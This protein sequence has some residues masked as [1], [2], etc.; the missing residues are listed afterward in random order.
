MNEEAHIEDNI[1]S[2]NTA[3][4]LTDEELA[5]VQQVEQTYRRLMKAG[6]T[7]CNYCMPCPS[8]VN[9][10]ACFEHFNSYHMF[11]GRTA[12]RLKYL[13]NLCGGMGVQKACASLCKKCGKCEE[14]CPQGLPIQEFLEEVAQTFETRSQKM[15][16]HLMKI[17][18][19]F[20][21]FSAI[22]RSKRTRARQLRG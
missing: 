17:F 6:C 7:G 12:V 20:Q 5:L 9:I 21:R 14:K 3:D 22:R 15:M 8:G 1:Q 10:P 18:F 19:S 2:A 11:N 13:G 4:A 16:A